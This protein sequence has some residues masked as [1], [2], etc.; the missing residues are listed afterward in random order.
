ML[1]TK[2]YTMVFLAYSNLY[3]NVADKLKSSYLLG[4]CLK[5]LFG[6]SIEAQTCNKEDESC[7]KIKSLMRIE[8]LTC[9]IHR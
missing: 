4:S 8:H 6:A 1:G 7:A 9:R 5:Y 2:A 3:L